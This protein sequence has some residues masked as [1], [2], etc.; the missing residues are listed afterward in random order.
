MRHLRDLIAGWRKSIV[1]V[2]AVLGLAIGQTL[3]LAPARPHVTRFEATKIAVAN[4]GA[5][6]VADR[7]QAKL[8]REWQLALLGGSGFNWSGRLLWA[9]L[10]P[11]G[12]FSHP[13][14]CCSAPPK[15]DWDVVLVYDQTGGAGLDGVVSGVGKPT[16][17]QF[18]PDLA[19]SG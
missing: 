18:L 7:V 19:Q 15:T 12:H 13:G 17:F 8:V 2:S 16:W 10:V 9:V 4:L 11:G 3:W 1:I 5:R 14:P 6:D